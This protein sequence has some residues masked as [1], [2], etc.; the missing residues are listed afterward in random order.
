MF[1][2]FKKQKNTKE[3]EINE[4]HIRERQQDIEEM[5]VDL[6]APLVVIDANW[7]TIKPMIKTEEIEKKEK[8]ILDL[9]KEQSGITQRL[10]E[11]SKIKQNLMQ[12]VLVI[13]STLS[14]RDDEAKRKD[15]GNRHEAILK[16]NAAL[17]VDEEK[18]QEVEQHIKVVNQ[19]LVHHIVA[20]S[21]AYMEVCKT[22]SETLGNEI[23]EL[24][25]T[26]L[27]KTNE[28]K[29]YD[30]KRGMLYQYLHHIIGYKQMNQVDKW[31]GEKE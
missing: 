13:S 31:L 19:Q 25:Q 12:E 16:I 7:Y 23:D 9:M 28:K 4:V 11:N 10:K 8:Q 17:K 6:T 30:A 29:S 24:R 22:T 2:K 1:K 20:A 26:L 18:L 21:Y 5:L 3:I 14:E 27:Q 15:L